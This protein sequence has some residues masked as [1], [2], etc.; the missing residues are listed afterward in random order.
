MNGI[1]TVQELH[2]AVSQVVAEIKMEKGE[3]FFFDYAGIAPESGQKFRYDSTPTNT[4]IFG[5]TG[6]D[7]VHY[8]LLELSETIQPIIMTVPMNHGKIDDYNHVIAENLNEF[9]GLGF[10]LGWFAL[11][12]ICY[13]FEGDTFGFYQKSR[14]VEDDS[15]DK[16]F[17]EKLRQKL[18]YGYVPFNEERLKEL[19]EKY[20]KY[21][22]FDK[23]FLE[24]N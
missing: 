8:S 14:K 11:E 2:K 23:E 3:D 24:R 13:S 7:G 19:K 4:Y 5:R 10:Y 15:C 12:Q 21:L 16:L 18:K 9:L 20:F 6:G 22:E 1:I 17:I